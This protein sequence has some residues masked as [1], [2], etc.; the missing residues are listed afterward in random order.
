MRELVHLCQREVQAAAGVRVLTS[1]CA[2]AGLGMG[3]A[4]PVGVGVGTSAWVEQR[5][6][7]IAGSALSSNTRPIA[8]RHPVTP[9]PTIVRMT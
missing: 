4:M 6:T 1:V 2:H 5:E 7:G 9:R 8:K 3:T